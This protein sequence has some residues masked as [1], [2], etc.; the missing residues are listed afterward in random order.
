[1]KQPTAASHVGCTGAPAANAKSIRSRKA[2][3]L[4]KIGVRFG[5]DI[6]VD[7]ALAR[8]RTGQGE[9]RL[10]DGGI[11]FG[12]G[13]RLQQPGTHR[14]EE[15]LQDGIANRRGFQERAQQTIA[16]QRRE[17]VRCTFGRELRRGQDA[18]GRGVAGLAGHEQ[19][20]RER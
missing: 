3:S 15:A 20:R 2:A 14:G 10:V 17:Q 12:L 4:H 18:L 16:R 1:M 11:R 5:K 19:E 9:R 6:F 7:E 8:Q 13:G